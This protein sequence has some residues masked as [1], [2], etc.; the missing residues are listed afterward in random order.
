[1]K[2]LRIKNHFLIA[3]FYD[4]LWDNDYDYTKIKGFPLIFTFV[5]SLVGSLIP[6]IL[7]VW[8]LIDVIDFTSLHLTR[9]FLFLLLSII[10]NFITVVMIIL[11]F[12]DVM[13]SINNHIINLLD[14][15]YSLKRG[16]KK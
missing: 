7:G 15:R 13:I 6:S 12:R 10:V 5:G 11:W 4:S 14:T 16:I 8:L 1:M 3:I 9:H 2:N